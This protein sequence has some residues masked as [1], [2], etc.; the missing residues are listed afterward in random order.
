MTLALT[1]APIAAGASAQGIIIC[2]I[3]L[4]G[5]DGLDVAALNNWATDPDAS[6]VAVTPDAADLKELFAELA[7][8]ISKPGAT[9]IVIDEVAE[10]DFVI[11]SILPPAKGSAVQ[12]DTRSLRWKIPELGVTGSES[13]A[14]EFL[15]RHVGQDSGTKL[16]NQSITYSDA[17]GNVVTFPRP[18]VTVVCDLAVCPEPCPDPVEFTAEGCSNVVLVDMGEVYL[19]AQGRIIEMEVTIKNV[20]PGKRTALAAILTEVDRNGTEYPRGMKTMTIPAHQ[21]AGC[22]DVRV[23]CIRFVV[24]EDLSVSGGAMC[25]PRRFKA[26]FLANSIDTDYFCD[27][28]VTAP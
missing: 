1:A 27:E 7:A 22:R 26:R 21:F 23:A 20:C 24:P 19:G 18:T 11:T 6:H 17:E 4:I 25:S 12:Q 10:P 28:P 9:D 3:G 16:V 13:A 8:N 2:C 5:S 15:I 14:L